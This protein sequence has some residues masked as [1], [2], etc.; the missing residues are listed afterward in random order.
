MRSFLLSFFTVCCDGFDISFMSCAGFCHYRKDCAEF[1]SMQTGIISPSKLRMKLISSQKKNDESNC[2]SSRTSPSRHE[3]SEF[4]MNSLLAAGNADFGDE[5]MNSLLL[6]ASFHQLNVWGNWDI[7][8]FEPFLL[9]G[10]EGNG[11]GF[12]LNTRSH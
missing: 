8:F 10:S 1:F 5:G 4:V 12:V 6:F 3:D 2:S 7:L 9:A 11:S